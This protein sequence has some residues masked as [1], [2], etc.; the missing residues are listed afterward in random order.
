MLNY[1]HL[2]RLM[3]HFLLTFSR[4]KLSV[5]L[6]YGYC[7]L[8]IPTKQI[9]DFST[10]KDGNVSRLSPSVRCVTA[11]NSIWKSRDVFNKHNIP[12]RT[13]FPLLNPQSYV[14]I[15]LHVLFYS[16]RLKLVLVLALIWIL[17]CIISVFA[18]YSP[19]AALNKGTEL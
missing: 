14:I 2:K 3:F 10:L 16:L 18:R 11:A 1:L 4:T 19:V 12:L 8:H 13:Y 6:Y 9:R 17:L 7:C 15:V 5:V